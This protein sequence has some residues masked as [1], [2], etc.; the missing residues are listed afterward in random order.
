MNEKRAGYWTVEAWNGLDA[1]GS[2]SGCQTRTLARRA[3]AYRLDRGA[4]RVYVRESVLGAPT[5]AS[6]TEGPGWVVRD[7]RLTEVLK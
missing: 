6:W 1:V 5:A 7:P 3:E 4:D 2:R